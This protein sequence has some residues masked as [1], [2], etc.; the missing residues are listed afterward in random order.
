MFHI[1]DND[2]VPGPSAI[3][4]N[5]F[6]LIIHTENYICKA[7]G[8]D[9]IDNRI[10]WNRLALPPSSSPLPCSAKGISSHVLM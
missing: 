10:D 9:R 6:C 3:A 4:P 5:L 1:I 2:E 7:T 8:I